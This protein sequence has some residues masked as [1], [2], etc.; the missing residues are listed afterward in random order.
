MSPNQNK[1]VKESVLQVES[2]N[3]KKIT[4]IILQWATL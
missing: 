4:L 3:S 1:T 2:F